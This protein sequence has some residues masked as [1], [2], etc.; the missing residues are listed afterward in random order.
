MQVT[1]SPEQ[2]AQ[3]SRIAARAGRGIDDL[4]HK[5]LDMYLAHEQQV[6]AEAILLVDEADALF[7]KRTEVQESHDRYSD[8]GEQD[9]QSTQGAGKP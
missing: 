6:K 5:V 4:V 3:L 1:L 8:Q 9:G 7:G 2:E